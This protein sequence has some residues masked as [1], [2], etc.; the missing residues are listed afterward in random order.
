MEL[1]RNILISFFVIVAITV[2]VI[3]LAY[4]KVE[5]TEIMPNTETTE[6]YIEKVETI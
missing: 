3:V 6:V 2:L 5:P 4:V 1:I